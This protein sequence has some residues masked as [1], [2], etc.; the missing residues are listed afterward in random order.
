MSTLTPT[1]AGGALSLATVPQN[2][3]PD[4]AALIPRS[5]HQ[6]MEHDAMQSSIL[7]DTST[8]R[9]VNIAIPLDNPSSLSMELTHDGKVT[10]LVARFETYNE[11]EHSD[12][13]RSRNSSLETVYPDS[14]DRDD[15]LSPLIPDPVAEIE[16]ASEMLPSPDVETRRQR[17]PLPSEWT[18]STQ[19]TPPTRRGAPKLQTELRSSEREKRKSAQSTSPPKTI[20]GARVSVDYGKSSSFLTKEKSKPTSPS[21]STPCTPRSRLARKE[22]KPKLTSLPQSPLRGQ[23]GS[24][25]HLTGSSSK[26]VSSLGHRRSDSLQSTGNTEYLSVRQPQKALDGQENTL[27]LRAPKLSL[28]I[29]SGLNDHNSSS[30]SGSASTPSSGSPTRSK[31]PRIPTKHST[32]QSSPK[33]RATLR[34]KP[35]AKRM[36]EKQSVSPT[37]QVRTSEKKDV[38]GVPQPKTPPVVRHVKTVDSTGATPII[39]QESLAKRERQPDTRTLVRSYLTQLPDQTPSTNTTSPSSVTPQPD[40]EEVVGKMLSESVASD[41][42]GSPSMSSS[43]GKAT[44]SDD[45]ALRDPAVIYSR[46]K[47]TGSESKESSHDRE[48]IQDAARTS[49]EV[50]S[51]ESPVRGRII[52]Q[53]PHGRKQTHSQHSLA[54]STLSDLR[55]TAPEFVPSEPSPSAPASTVLPFDP[56]ALDTYGVPW[57]YHMY[58]VSLPKS[59]QWFKSPRK[60]KTAPR[61]RKHGTSNTSTSPQ[62]VLAE[63]QKFADEPDADSSASGQALPFAAQLEEIDRSVKGQTLPVSPARKGRRTFRSLHRGA[64]NGLYDDSYRGHHLGSGIPIDQTAPFPDPIPP[65]GNAMHVGH[66]V[67]KSKPGCG[68]AV[69]ETSAEWIGGRSCHGCEP[70]H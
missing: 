24:P 12:G 62:K 2:D 67:E 32:L 64:G 65:S 63:L 25:L 52:D 14:E 53:A 43:S 19:T 66:V 8:Y 69:L 17:K 21:S 1:E 22:S 46:K 50:I 40:L 59:F 68:S 39:T 26:T 55:A 35:A 15:S 28:T 60:S 18:Q 27:K 4:H 44:T 57:L 5:A 31:I 47:S 49:K 30:A 54:S 61:A 9:N 41:H 51:D 56:F 58:P 20:R 33:T 34:T 45:T 16:S 29:P 6:D 38:Q 42:G 48:S 36:A 7:L 10:E 13:H 23:T 37:E 11:T 70:D 3:H